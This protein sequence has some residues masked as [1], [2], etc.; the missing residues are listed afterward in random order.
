MEDASAGVIVS[1]ALANSIVQE[2]MSETYKT[3]HQVLIEKIG[4]MK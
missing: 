4:T 1:Y 2:G 3:N